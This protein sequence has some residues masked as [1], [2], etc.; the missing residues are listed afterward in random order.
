MY[1]TGYTP[2]DRKIT[3]HPMG[4][5]LTLKNNKTLRLFY[6]I[7]AGLHTRNPVDATTVKTVTSIVCALPEVK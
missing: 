5:S 3:G 6:V 4:I 1:L 7:P 2:M